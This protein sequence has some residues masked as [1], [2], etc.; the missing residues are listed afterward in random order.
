VKRLLQLI[1]PDRPKP[2]LADEVKRA[3]SALEQLR[4]EHHDAAQRAAAAMD[5]SVQIARDALRR[6]GGK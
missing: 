4:Q 6:Q 2:V 3:N 5:E 1:R